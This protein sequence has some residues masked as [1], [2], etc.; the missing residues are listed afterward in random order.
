MRA[1]QQ[2]RLEISKVLQPYNVTYTQFVI[3]MSIWY[4]ARH[5][6]P[7]TQVLVGEYAAV[8]INVTSQVIRKLL[9]RG[10]IKRSVKPGDSRAYA[11]SLTAAGESLAKATGQAAEQFHKSFFGAINQQNLHSELLRLIKQSNRR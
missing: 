6:S 7:P 8:D 11:L 4:Q 3:V 5:L 1:A 2:Y 9:S 10:L